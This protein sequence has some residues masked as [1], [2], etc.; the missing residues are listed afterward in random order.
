M[1]KIIMQPAREQVANFLRQQIFDGKIKTNDELTQEQIADS[2]GVSRMPVREAFQILDQEGILKVQKRKAIVQ[3][4]TVE[5]VA[6]HLEIRGLLEGEAAFKA[7]TNYGKDFQD[8]QNALKTIEECTLNMDVISYIQANYAFHKEVWN[9]SESK[10]L[11]TV[12]DY[13][14]KGL[15]SNLPLLLPEQMD[16]SLLEHQKIVDC[17]VNN[18]PESAK[19]VMM[20]HIH[21]SIEDF[22]D[23]YNKRRNQ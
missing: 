3:P 19:K 22:I 17:I 5:D 2:L 1:N 18:K 23:H 7:A 6:D 4:F 14:W 8:L 13:L 11:I 16:K 20:Q 9:A 12:L 21:R 15:P 10:R